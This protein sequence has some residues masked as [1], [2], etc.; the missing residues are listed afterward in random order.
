MGR[1]ALYVDWRIAI[2]SAEGIRAVGAPQVQSF[3]ARG[4]SHFSLDAQRKVTKRKCTRAARPRC[5]WVRGRGRNFRKG[6]PAPA[7]NGAHPCA[8]PCG[9]YLPRPPC[10]TGPDAS[11]AEAKATTTASASASASASAVASQHAKSPCPAWASARTLAP[12]RALAL[13][14]DFAS[15]LALAPAPLS[16]K[17]SRAPQWEAAVEAPLSERSE[18]GRR[19]A[20]R[21]EHRA[22]TRL[23]RVGSRPAQTVLLT[24]A[25]TKVSR[26]PARK[27]WTLPLPHMKSASHAP[28]RREASRAPQG[29]VAVE[30][31]LSERSEFG[32]RAASREEHRAPTRLHRV[33]S[34]P[35]GNGFTARCALALRA[36]FAVRSA[37]LRSA[38]FCQ[39]KSSS[40]TAR[41]LL[42]SLPLCI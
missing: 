21:E 32:R 12:A 41:K 10:L 13:A 23:H 6:H 33:G 22:P 42:P 7:G 27:L 5:A 8:P 36:G 4:A 3:R 14:T 16:R 25:K 35:G 17:V 15:A 34:R 30:A 37:A 9:L 31:P 29:G 24:F 18:F 39:D 40:R 2:A 11:K 26:A 20:S 19:A 1:I 28:L 38:Y